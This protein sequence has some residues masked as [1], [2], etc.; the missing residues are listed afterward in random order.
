MELGSPIRV[1]AGAYNEGDKFIFTITN[2]PT[3]LEVGNEIH[4]LLVRR[5]KVLALFFQSACV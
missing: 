4:W 5:S 3:L 2:H 1:K